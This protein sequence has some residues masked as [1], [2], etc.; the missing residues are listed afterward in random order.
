MKVYRKEKEALEG[1]RDVHWAK[2]PSYRNK[3]IGAGQ[4]LSP[5]SSGSQRPPRNQTLSESKAIKKNIH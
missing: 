4:T 3:M 2:G 5:S 1:V